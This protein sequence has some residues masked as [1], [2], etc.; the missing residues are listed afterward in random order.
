MDYR[1]DKQPPP[2]KLVWRKFRGA[3]QAIHSWV[4]GRFPRT[5]SA[6]DRILEKLFEAFG[7]GAFGVFAA[8]LLVVLVAT[9]VIPVIVAVPLFVAWLIAVVWLARLKVVKSLTVLSRWLIVLIGGAAFAFAAHGLGRWALTQYDRTE[10]LPQVYRN[11]LHAFIRVSVDEHHPEGAMVAGVPWREGSI[12]ATVILSTEPR[13]KLFDVELR[14]TFNAQLI[15][16]MQVTQVPN[17]TLQ[18]VQRNTVQSFE[19]GGLDK[20]GKPINPRTAT[21]EDIQTINSYPANQ[22]LFKQSETFPDLPVILVFVGGSGYQLG[23]FTFVLP[24]KAAA[25]PS[26]LKLMGTYTAKYKGKVYMIP[27]KEEI[28]KP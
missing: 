26:D 2:I 8:L 17:V 13:T 11:A 10:E 9:N 7:H 12:L 19:A 20:N 6:V 4:T 27:Y 24:N 15:H 21:P 14:L 25:Y 23:N 3:D 18:P 22:F 16:G 5:M 1:K 28:R